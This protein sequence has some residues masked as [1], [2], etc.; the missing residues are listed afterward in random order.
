[1]NTRTTDLLSKAFI[2]AAG[3]AVGAAVTWRYFKTQ[4]VEVDVEEDSDEGNTSKEM[5]KIGEEAA[6]GFA[7]GIKEVDE[8]Y[9]KMAQEICEKHNYAAYSR[10]E[11]KE[12]DNMDKPHVISPEEFGELDY[13]MKSLTLYSDG[14]LVSENGIP[15]QDVE[16]TVGKDSLKHFGEYEDDSVFVRNDAKKIDYEI[17]YD[18]RKFDEMTEA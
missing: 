18:L 11:K 8:K 5:K 14:V 15:I 17:L 10:D 9:K 6:K 13:K 4:Y 2:F 3:A 7:D 1:M 12:E 16:G